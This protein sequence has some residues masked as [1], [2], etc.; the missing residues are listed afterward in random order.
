MHD[1]GYVHCDLKPDNILIGLGKKRN[2][3]Y[4]IDF[5]LSHNFLD[6][7]KNHIAH[8]LKAN[9]KGSFS[10]CSLNLLNKQRKYSLLFL[11]ILA[12]ETI[13]NP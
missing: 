2:T 1:A 7:N 13:L 11:K 12:E 3:I 4:L 10:Y 6:E 8:P 9:F 5:G